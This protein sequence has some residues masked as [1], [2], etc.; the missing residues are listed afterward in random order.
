MRPR[1]G[2]KRVK[3]PFPLTLRQATPDDANTLVDIAVAAYGPS[4]GSTIEF[5]GRAQDFRAAFVKAA[6]LIIANTT[7]AVLDSDIIGFSALKGDDGQ[8]GDVWVRPQHQNAGIG[9][10]LLAASEARVRH[11]GQGCTW[12]KT[13]AGNIGALGF[14]RTHGYALLSVGQAPWGAQT[15]VIYPKAVLGK[16]LSR[17]QAT[18][19]A[20][21][22]DVRTGIDTLDPMLVA[23]IAERFTFIDRAA[24]LKPALAMPARVQERVEEVITNARNQAARLGFDPELTEKLWRTMVDL[25]IE[26]EERAFEQQRA[27]TQDTGT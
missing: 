1:A 18:K 3:A 26:R 25:A 5:A 20:T 2:G 4:I 19:A 15:D 21:M 22:A 10:M 17:P 9:A 23:L 14:Y 27:Q 7:V 6:P 16:Q 12:L 24:D 8:I 13:H 11:L